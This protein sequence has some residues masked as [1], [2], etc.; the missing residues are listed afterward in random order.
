MTRIKVDTDN[1]HEGDIV[2]ISMVRKGNN[3]RPV[4][5]P[6]DY[7][8]MLLPK[9]EQK[10]CLLAGA[11]VDETDIIRAKREKVEFE[12]L[13]KPEPIKKGD[14]LFFNNQTNI[15]AYQ[16]NLSWAM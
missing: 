15:I 2:K 11:E 16:D 7:G 6:V 3:L 10:E 9:P 4:D 12:V 13:I 8:G 5:S 14:I 1:I